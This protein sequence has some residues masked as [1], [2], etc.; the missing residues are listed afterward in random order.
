VKVFNAIQ[1]DFE[2]QMSI[3]EA[4]AALREDWTT[5]IRALIAEYKALRAR[6]RRQ[7]VSILARLLIDICTHQETQR[8]LTREQAQGLQPGL[9]HVFYGALARREKLAHGQLKDLYRDH[10]LELQSGDLPS[11]E[12]LFDTEKWIVWGLNRR[13]LL[14]AAA[15]AGAATGAVVD[16]GLAGHSLFLGALTGGVIAGGG[17]WLG[18]NRLADFKISGLPVGGY[19]A[20]QGPIRN[21]NFPYVVLSRFLFLHDALQQRTHARRDTLRIDEGDLSV[22]I[23]RLAGDQQ[24]AL[25]RQMDR[26]ARQRAPQRLEEVLTPLLV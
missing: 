8:I 23:D 2:K 5:T 11:E 3:L 25:H 13:Q 24:K 22:R 20:R 7:S 17:A 26:L 12:N 6:Q 15:M 16:L 4:F 14:V 21:R 10:K 1:A 19:E 18:A 9:E